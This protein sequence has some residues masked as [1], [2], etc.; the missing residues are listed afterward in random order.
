MV[1]IV[2][3]DNEA[4]DLLHPKLRT[5]LAIHVHL[6]TLCKVRLFQVPFGS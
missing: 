2:T 4:H 1:F 3:D 5:D 6:D